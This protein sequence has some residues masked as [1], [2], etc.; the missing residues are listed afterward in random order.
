MKGRRPIPLAI[1]K[2]TGNPGRR[3]MLPE[4]MPLRLIPECPEFLHDY[5]KD[6]WAFLAPELDRL[7]L[8]T[9]IDLGTFALLCS[10]WADWRLNTEAVL[11]TTNGGVYKT[12]NGY[13]AQIPQ[14]SMARAAGA[15]YSKLASEFG[16]SPSSRT[17][18]ADPRF[19]LFDDG[20]D[21]DLDPW[22]PA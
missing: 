3:P 8:I 17:R 16:L 4:P 12:G 5:A 18:L 9:M 2:L 19:A 22:G 13:L 14:I 21:S 7:G 15:V 1:R 20:D 10:A 11:L 6:H